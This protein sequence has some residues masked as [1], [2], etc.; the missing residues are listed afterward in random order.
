MI[1]DRIA[2]LEAAILTGDSGGSYADTLYVR[3]GIDLNYPSIGTS[4][5][6]DKLYLE[7]G[8]EGYKTTIANLVKGLPELDASILRTTGTD[9]PYAGA[10]FFAADDVILI[11]SATGSGIS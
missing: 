1:I 10:G 4:I 7:R 3:N 2:G 6:S 9:T 5:L 8:N 11:G